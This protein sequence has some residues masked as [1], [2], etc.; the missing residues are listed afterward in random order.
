MKDGHSKK[1]IFQGFDIMQKKKFSNI[2]FWAYA[3]VL[4]FNEVTWH[5]CKTAKKMKKSIE[6][7]TSIY[8]LIINLRLRLFG[9]Q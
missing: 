2:L 5:I 7:K 6:N 1:S 4:D 8:R 3:H 9:R